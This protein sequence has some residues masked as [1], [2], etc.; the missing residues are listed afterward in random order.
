MNVSG[1]ASGV[2]LQWSTGSSTSSANA[3]KIVISDNGEVRNLSVAAAHGVVTMTG[4]AYASNVL[5]AGSFASMTMAAGT[6]AEAVNVRG[7]R[8]NLVMLCG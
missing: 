4:N 6:S 7:N 1:N 8:A 2:S 5:L 3:P